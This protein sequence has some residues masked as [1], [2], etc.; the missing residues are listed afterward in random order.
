M[1]KIPT[2]CIFLFLLSTAGCA[3][4]KNNSEISSHND[5][6]SSQSDTK[7]ESKKDTFETDAIATIDENTN[8]SLWRSEDNS[9]EF[10]FSDDIDL[11]DRLS[12]AGTYKFNDKTYDIHVSFG[13][14]GIFED[15]NDFQ[16]DGHL[17]V[18]T[19]PSNDEKI[20]IIVGDYYFDSNNELL[21]VK[22]IQLYEEYD[23]AKKYKKDHLVKFHK[24]ESNTKAYLV[25]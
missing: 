15:N 4:Q 13:Y 24:V 3:L 9:I 22:Q 1:R 25:E 14:G 6:R 21:V 23:F 10:S 16:S 8:Y 19:C 12:F 5:N 17:V 20:D 2:C 7:E 18:Y 11:L